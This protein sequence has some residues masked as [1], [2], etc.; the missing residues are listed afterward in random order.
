[1]KRVLLAL[2]ALMAAVSIPLVAVTTQAGAASP[3]GSTTT[4]ATGVF[5]TGSTALPSTVT[6]TVTTRTGAVTSITVGGTTTYCK[7]LYATYLLN[8]SFIHVATYSMD[9]YFCYNDVIVTTHTTTEYGSVTSAG[10]LIGWNYTGTI[11]REFNCYTAGDGHSCSGNHE[12]A[13]GKFRLCVFKIGCVG[14]W[15]PIINEYERYKGG[16]TVDFS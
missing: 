13:E 4:V 12:E 9:T 2:V 8:T 5:V 3:T 15:Y 6:L 10:S 11:A 7:W 14:S 16:T 1:M